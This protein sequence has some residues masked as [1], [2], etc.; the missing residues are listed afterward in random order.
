MGFPKP[1]LRFR[2]FTAQRAL[3]APSCQGSGYLRVEGHLATWPRNKGAV[4]SP[5]HHRGLTIDLRSQIV[6][7][8][9]LI[10]KIILLNAVH[11]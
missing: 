3:H 1:R 11:P 10:C 6:L 7:I 8:C 5:P 4:T 2:V 9:T